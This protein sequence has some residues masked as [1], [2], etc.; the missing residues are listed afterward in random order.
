MNRI[1]DLLK[2]EQFSAEYQAINPAGTV[3][4]LVDGDFKLFDSC[5]ISIYLVEKYAKNDDLYPRDPI[6]R[7][8]VNEKLFYCASTVFP[9]GTQIFFPIIFGKAEKVNDEVVK[10][11]ERIFGTIEEFLT[12]N[13]FIAGDT[14]TLPDF[15][16]WSLIESGSR[17]MKLD[18]NKLPNTIKW[19]EVMREHP[20]NDFMQ[21]GADMHIAIL[22][23][24]MEKNKTLNK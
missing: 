11:F 23:K 2:G 14:M 1:V 12:A 22:N 8:K 3:P 6:A 9:M 7:A 19:L 4:T 20:S 15:Y 17:V 21:Q 5:A 13:K 16:L 10:K 18:E 24:C